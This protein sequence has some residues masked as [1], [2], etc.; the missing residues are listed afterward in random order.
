M[1]SG[2]LPITSTVGEDVE[3]VPHEFFSEHNY[4]CSRPPTENEKND[5]HQEKIHEKVIK[6]VDNNVC[7]RYVL[8]LSL[9]NRLI[10]SGFK[11]INNLFNF[12]IIVGLKII[13]RRFPKGRSI[14]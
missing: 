12:I 13:C 7:T 3:I 6:P 9:F 8:L 4:S 2:A 10:E 11:I 14:Y 1:K 5:R